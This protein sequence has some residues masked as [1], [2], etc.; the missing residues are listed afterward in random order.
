MSGRHVEGREGVG[1]KVLCRG[2]RCP[3]HRDFFIVLSGWVQA[4][5][6]GGGG[7]ATTVEIMEGGI[8]ESFIS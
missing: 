1:K 6:P 5:T 4:M 8:D 2:Q 3:H 7:K